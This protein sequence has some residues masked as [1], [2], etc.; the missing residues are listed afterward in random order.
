MDPLAHP[1]SKQISERL[2]E[3]LRVDLDLSQENDR[4][5]LLVSGANWGVARLLKREVRK[6]GDLE[7]ALWRIPVASLPKIPF[8]QSAD[9]PRQGKVLWIPGWGDSP[10]S[11]LG[12]LAGAFAGT[13]YDEVVVL[14]FPGFHGSLAH[15][16][17]ITDMDRILEISRDTIQEFRPEVVAGHSLGGWLASWSLLH[18]KPEIT[19]PRELVLIAPS[20]VTGTEH[21]RLRWREEIRSWTE[22]DADGYLARV[23]ATPPPVVG[24]FM[25]QFA[26]FMVREDTQEFLASVQD[27]HFLDEK[28]AAMGSNVSLLWG[29][30]DGVVPERFATHWISR[31]PSARYERWSGVGHMPH[32]EAPVRLVRWLRQVLV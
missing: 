30:E 31:L 32:M 4:L 9:K 12:V 10:M 21:E 17:C 19:V 2:L 29:A 11:W 14:D 3:I 8:V 16:S 5:R 20:G 28:L 13:S 27:H 25:K 15:R 7:W 22:S 6:R 18:L 26:P 23:F 1:I 24:N